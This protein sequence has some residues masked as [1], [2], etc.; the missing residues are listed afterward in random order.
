MEF[1]NYLG[2]CFFFQ[3]EKCSMFSKKMIISILLT[4]NI[5]L[6]KHLPMIFMIMFTVDY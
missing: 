2:E 5:L 3:T 4:K 6:P 1:I